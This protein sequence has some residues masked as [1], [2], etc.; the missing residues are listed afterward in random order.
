M[1]NKQETTPQLEELW[2]F[3]GQGLR[4]NDFT[5]AMVHFYRGELGRSNAWRQRLDT[6]TNWAVITTGAALTFAFGDLNNTPTVI[7]IDTL[8]VLLFLFIEARRY[9]Y[10]ELWTSRVRIMETNFFVGLLSPPFLPHTGWAEQLTQSL[11][12]PQFPISLL[13]AFGRRYR[14]NYA[15]IFLIL[16][17]SW[18]GKVYVH[19]TA[20]SHLAQFLQRAAIGPFPGWL[21]VMVGFVFNGLLLLIGV[22]SIGLQESPGEVLPETPNVLH[23][24]GQRLRQLTWETMDVDLPRWPPAEERKQ[25]AYIIS[26]QVEPVSQALMAELQRGVTLLHGQGMYTGAEHGVLMCALTQGQVPRCKQI[27]LTIDPKAVVIISPLAEVRGGNGF[28]PLE[29]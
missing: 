18:V 13:E 29:A 24:L 23:R 2:Q 14:R 8:L 22:F 3:A 1:T 20:V 4:S 15:W 19:P 28:R 11:R 10:Y 26:D 6:T 25:L 7:L 9:R 5:A 21:V 17:F 16:A 12:H 27:V